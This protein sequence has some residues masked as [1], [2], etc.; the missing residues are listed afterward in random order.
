MTSHYALGGKPIRKEIISKVLDLSSEE[1]IQRITGARIV[2]IKKAVTCL[3]QLLA[4]EHIV[5]DSG[6]RNYFLEYPSDLNPE[7]FL[8]DLFY[9]AIQCSRTELM[10]IDGEIISDILAF[11]ENTEDNFTLDGNQRHSSSDN[12][13]IPT[14]STENDAVE[15][16]GEIDAVVTIEDKEVDI[17]QKF[18]TPDF[19]IN[20]GFKFRQAN[21]KS[22]RLDFP[23]HRELAA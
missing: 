16:K 2:N 1:R 4:S 12:I 23:K 22:A 11:R 14:V 10:K 6:I 13:S 9:E 8:G 5:M 18:E 7:S 20:G 15:T 21:I 3:K 19:L 17:Y